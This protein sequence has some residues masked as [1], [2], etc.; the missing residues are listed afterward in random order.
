MSRSKPRKEKKPLD[1]EGLEA[2]ALRYVERYA[3]T[4]RKLAGYLNRKLFERGW[5]GNREPD[6]VALAEKMADLRYI[7]DAAYAESR[8]NSLT[9]RGYGARRVEQALF[10]AGIGEE[11]GAQARDIAAEARWESALAFA[12]RRKIGPFAAE[13][14]DERDRRRAFAAMARAGHDFDIARRLI[15]ARPGEIPESFE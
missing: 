3:T 15:D 8:A 14:P 11:D 13:K 2:L 4:R 12:R 5:A 9:R 1:E 6:P 10:A 7:D